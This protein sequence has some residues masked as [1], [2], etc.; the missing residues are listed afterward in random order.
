MR[1]FLAVVT[2]FMLVAGCAEKAE[3]YPDT[4]EAVLK[5]YFNS[6]YDEKYDQAVKYYGGTY[7]ELQDRYPSIKTNNHAELFK[8]YVTIT[9]GQVLNINSILE[10]AD[11][12]AGEEYSFKLTFVNK[13]GKLFR[14]GM[15]HTYIVKK[16]NGQYKVMDLPPYLS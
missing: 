13:E 5:A 12:I 9:T 8:A 11:I 7:E 15:I 6:L 14:E 2:L 10:T 3:E 4:P 16:V 1:F